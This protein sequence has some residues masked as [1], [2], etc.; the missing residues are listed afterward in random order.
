MERDNFKK[1]IDSLDDIKGIALEQKIIQ[2]QRQDIVEKQA[3]LKK[4]MEKFQ[5]ESKDFNLLKSK[6]YVEKNEQTKL[7]NIINNMETMNIKHEVVYKKTYTFK[8]SDLEYV[9]EEYKKKTKTFYWR[10]EERII[11][12][13]VFENVYHFYLK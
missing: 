5:M 8:P 11:S 12:E 2:E 3:L 13:F 6:V 9:K 1:I 7:K 4:E 10:F